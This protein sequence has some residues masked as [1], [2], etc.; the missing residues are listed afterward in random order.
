[1]HVIAIA[2]YLI[3]GAAFL[4]GAALLAVSWR[5]QRIGA[6]LIVAS[7]VMTLWSVF[8]AYAEWTRA[9]SANWILL[10][11]VLRFGAWLA[12]VSALFGR[13]GWGFGVHVLWIALAC[14]CVW[15]MSGLARATGLMLD[16]SVPLAGVLVLAL[17]GVVFLE[18]IY[19]NVDPEQ[20]WALKFL[21]I[22]LGVLFAYDIFLY[23]Y[24]VL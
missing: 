1:M 20:R 12:F 19:R 3:C 17:L 18:Q 4:I 7:L 8:L 24:A 13:R 6:L 23:S 11:E 14:C 22:A 9:V 10:A 21:V 5:G 2:S 16:I 15:P